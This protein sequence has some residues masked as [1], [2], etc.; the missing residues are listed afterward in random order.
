MDIHLTINQIC[1][2]LTVLVW[3]VAFGWPMREEHGDF[4]F[5]P[6][7]ALFGRLILAAIATPTIWLLGAHLR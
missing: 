5:G 7:F 3:I 4:D 6:M 2:I 1:G